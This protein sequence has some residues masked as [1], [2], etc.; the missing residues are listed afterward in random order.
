MS[1]NNID[2]S[3]FYALFQGA[4]EF[5]LVFP[6]DEDGYGPFWNESGE[7][8]VRRVGSQ[9]EEEV[10]LVELGGGLYRLANRLLG[11]FTGLRL[12]WGDEF[13]AEPAADNELILSRVAMPRMFKHYQFMA[14]GPLSNDNQIAQ[15]I[16]SHGG[17]WEAVAMGMLTITVPANAVVDFEQEMEDK[18][19]IPGIFQLVV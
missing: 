2:P 7:L 13:F 4:K 3:P 14:S 15:I 9:S 11:P 18:N 16:H 10:D 8:D 17:G 6:A 19:L 1:Q 5:V 12:Y